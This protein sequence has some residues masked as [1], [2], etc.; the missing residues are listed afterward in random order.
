M[1]SSGKY[2]F[3]AYITI[4]S[5]SEKHNVMHSRDIQQVQLAGQVVAS[6]IS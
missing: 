1:G 2:S 3:N 5:A 4:L 6:A